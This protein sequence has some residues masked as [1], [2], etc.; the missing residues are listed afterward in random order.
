MKNELKL[1]LKDLLN[2]TW[3]LD[4]FYLMAN[5]ACVTYCKSTW[6]SILNFVAATLIICTSNVCLKVVIPEFN[7]DKVNYVWQIFVILCGGISFYI[8]YCGY[9]V[10]Y[11]VAAVIFLSLLCG[12]IVSNMIKSYVLSKINEQ[13]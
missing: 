2:H 13:S 11:L 7:R 9:S 4:C 8:S 10:W 1:E 5:V 3:K 6:V 12:I